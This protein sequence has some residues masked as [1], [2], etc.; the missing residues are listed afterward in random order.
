MAKK[1]EMQKKVKKQ[2]KQ[3]KKA[4]KKIEKAE[5]LQE[6]QQVNK[7]VTEEVKEQIM[8]EQETKEEPKSIKKDKILII[9]I[10]IV[11][12]VFGIILVG[13]KLIGN[14]GEQQ[15]TTETKVFN[16]YVFEK[17]GDIWSTRIT[18]KD[19]ATGKLSD[20]DIMFHYTPDEVSDIDTLRNAKNESIAPYLFLNSKLVYVT[21]EPDYP[22]SAILAG[23]EIA[24][25]IAQIY[26]KDVKGALAKN[27][28]NTVTPIA[29]CDNITTTQTVIYLKLGNS[30]GIYNNKGCVVVQGRNT[31]ELLKASERLAFEM[32]KIL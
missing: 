23:V 32:L 27:S 29:T 18:K 5:K 22:A 7:E 21:T 9:G 13:I 25:I 31:E 20:F 11:L 30:T 8:Q 26:G 10:L 4:G 15:V 28:T 16:G 14:G 24:K 19:L 1:S 12:F 2:K 6:I 17:Y 3:E